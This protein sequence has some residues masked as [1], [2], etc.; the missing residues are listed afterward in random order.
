[1]APSAPELARRLADALEAADVPYAVGGAL[2]LGVWGV[3]RATNDV[4]LDIFVEPD[5]L[6][7]VLPVLRSAGCE[8][9]DDDVLHSARDRGDFDM[10]LEGMRIDV[11]VACVPFYESVERRVR[12]APLEG[13]PASYLSPEDLTVF[14]FLFFRIKDLLDVERLVAFQGPDLD[15]D[16]V[17]KWLVDLVGN[18]DER[19]ARWDRM[20]ADI[21]AGPSV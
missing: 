15:R 2:A 14:K 3:P 9:S 5:D 21:D 13:R 4:D 1:M 12:K 11:F 8:F 18:D 20:L 6:P 16:Y 19:L 17:R 10:Q 7:P